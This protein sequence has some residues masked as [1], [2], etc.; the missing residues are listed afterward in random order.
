MEYSCIITM[1]PER[2]RAELIS[3]ATRLI[4]VRVH[5]GSAVTATAAGGNILLGGGEISP[6]EF[7]M[8]F[9]ALC[10]GAPYAYENELKRGFL[11][12]GGCR[13]GVCGTA[14]TDGESIVGIKDIASLNIRFAREIR[15]AAD[16]LFER[17]G[18]S[19]SG[20]L[21]LVGPPACGKT[22]L[23]RELA[24]L[25]SESGR[26]V[27]VIDERGELAA[28]SHAARG[29]SLGT[30]TDVLDGYPKTAG[31]ELALRCLSPEVIICDEIGAGEA[32]A[33]C[34]CADCGV[35]VVAAVHG[36]NER[37]RR[38]SLL[39]SSGCFRRAAFFKPGAIGIIE[40]ITDIFDD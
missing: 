3:L 30:H 19:A 29:T 24:R 1:L 36:A 38:Y 28:V 18:G 14:L 39:A 7:D 26:R 8:L 16:A 12:L 37:S 25:L 35:D 27:C 17:L 10:D 34:E 31:I 15:G 13:V 23:L 32:D 33:V 20:G 5:R 21:L 2:Y 4:E 6:E 9:Y 22:T 11:T 40:R